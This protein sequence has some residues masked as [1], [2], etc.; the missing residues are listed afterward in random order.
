M[1]VLTEQHFPDSV[2]RQ[3]KPSWQCLE[4]G[5]AAPR[6]HSQQ[7]RN[8]QRKYTGS[9]V[10]ESRQAR[11]SQ[12]LPAHLV[13]T[14]LFVW[15]PLLAHDCGDTDTW[16]MEQGRGCCKSTPCLWSD[17]SDGQD[18][19]HNSLHAMLP[20]QAPEL[21]KWSPLL[22]WGWVPAWLGCYIISTLI[23]I[24]IAKTVIMFTPLGCMTA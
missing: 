15:S 13:T 22:C 8:I 17:L 21:S 6:Q 19:T 12:A 9:S 14:S 23:I 4:R 7:S 24:N 16:Y 2:V 1:S 5:A 18:T 10:S 20:C 3:T 11:T